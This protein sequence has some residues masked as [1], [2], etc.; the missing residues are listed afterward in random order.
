MARISSGRTTTKPGPK[1]F[2]STS[3]GSAQAL[4]NLNPNMALWVP[5]Q[6]VGFLGRLNYV[7]IIVR[8]QIIYIL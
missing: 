5:G 3:F 4:Q 7:K 8:S 1:I 6:L 2:L